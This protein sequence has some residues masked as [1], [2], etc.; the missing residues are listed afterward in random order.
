MYRFD[1][2]IRRVVD[3]LYNGKNHRKILRVGTNHTITQTMR[4]TAMWLVP[5]RNYKTKQYYV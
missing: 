5:R 1:I 2:S 3:E 4:P